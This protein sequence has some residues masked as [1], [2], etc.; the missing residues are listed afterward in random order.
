MHFISPTR[1]KLEIGEMCDDIGKF[2]SQH[3]RDRFRLIIGTDSQPGKATCFVTAIIV[4]REGKGARFY[5][6]RTYDKTPFTLRHRIFEEASRSLE[7]AGHI[8]QYLSSML[9]E[10]TIEIHVDI[11]E[12]GRTRD[13]IQQVVQMINLSG[14][15]AK[16]KP[17]SYG[18]TKVAD[19]FTK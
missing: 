13:L 12:K 14:F 7:M 19:R 17:F 18:A 16:V 6:R 2:V 8:I 15:A 11:G 5:Y 4:H 1:G 3:P 9:P 10:V